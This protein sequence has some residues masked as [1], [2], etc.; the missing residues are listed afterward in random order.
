MANVKHNEHSVTVE[1]DYGNIELTRNVLSKAFSGNHMISV[2]TERNDYMNLEIF[3]L[4]NDYMTFHQAGRS[5]LL[6]M[7]FDCMMEICIHN[8]KFLNEGI[9]YC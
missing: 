5:N 3:D 9:L 1:L 8:R 6:V 4:G 7:K 2:K